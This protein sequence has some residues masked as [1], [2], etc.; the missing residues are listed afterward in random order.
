M[1]DEEDDNWAAGTKKKN[2][3][4]K[5]KWT[6][7]DFFAEYQ[8][9]PQDFFYE[10][11]TAKPAELRFTKGPITQ[12]F[13]DRKVL[14][15]FFAVDLYAAAYVCGLEKG[16][17]IRVALILGSLVFLMY[18]IVQFLFQVLVLKPITVEGQTLD[19]TWAGFNDAASA[20]ALVIDCALTFLIASADPNDVS[21]VFALAG[22]QR[23]VRFLRVWAYWDKVYLYHKV[24]A[25]SFLE[26][27][28]LQREERAE[29]RAT[30]SVIDGSEGGEHARSSTNPLLVAATT[31]SMRSG[32]SLGKPNDRMPSI[33]RMQQ[34]SIDRTSMR[35]RRLSGASSTRKHNSGTLSV[36]RRSR[37]VEDEEDDDDELDLGQPMSSESRK[38]RNRFS[39]LASCRGCRLV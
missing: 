34:R 14:A 36:G 31:S 21:F 19:F 37:R 2:K 38:N 12:W 20:V 16:G 13:L 8:P 17:A 25:L 22:V 27:L 26:E 33:I 30:G 18:Y 39:M 5:K 3:K 29:S 24:R 7:E 11:D 9:D 10:D 23:A 32:A 28:D 15:L 4:K 6:P 35:L 1:G